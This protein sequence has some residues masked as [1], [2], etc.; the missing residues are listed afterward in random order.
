MSEIMKGTQLIKTPTERRG[1]KDSAML[2]TCTKEIAKMGM[3][4][5]MPKN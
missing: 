1:I 2:S 5:F 3:A 4:S